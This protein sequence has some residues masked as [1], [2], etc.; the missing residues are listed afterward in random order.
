MFFDTVLLICTAATLGLLT[1][2]VLSLRGV[3]L[4]ML[5]DNLTKDLSEIRTK[6]DFKNLLTDSQ[7]KIVLQYPKLKIE[8]H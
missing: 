8:F 3:N 1:G 6:Q 2:G 7:K 5:R 4:L